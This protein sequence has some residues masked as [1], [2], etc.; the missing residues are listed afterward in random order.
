MATE[1]LILKETATEKGTVTETETAKE[2]EKEIREDAGKKEAH[3]AH[4]QGPFLPVPCPTES[5]RENEYMHSEGI[6]SSF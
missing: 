1:T 4:H 3:M 2:T 5:H 6:E